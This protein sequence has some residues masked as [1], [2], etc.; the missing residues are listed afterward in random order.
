MPGG[1]LP[2]LNELART[3]REGDVAAARALARRAP[4]SRFPTFVDFLK[5]FVPAG[6]LTTD[7]FERFGDA[8]DLAEEASVRAAM[9]TDEIGVPAGK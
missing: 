4:R 1:R 6:E 5:E 9:D 7:V 8:W 2:S 3:A